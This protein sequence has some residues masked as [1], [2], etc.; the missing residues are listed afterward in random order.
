MQAAA[1]FHTLKI[2]YCGKFLFC[3]KWIRWKICFIVRL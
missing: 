1:F 2:C 3:K